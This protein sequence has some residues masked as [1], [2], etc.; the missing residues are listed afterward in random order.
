MLDGFQYTSKQLE[1][2]QNA[3]HRWNIA[4]GAVR[5]GKSHVALHHIIPQRVLAGRG[6]KGLNFLLGVSLGN[7][8][9]NVL[10]PMR[11]CFGSALVG[12]IRT[13]ENKARLFGEDVY[14]LGA[15]NK[16][17]LQR[18]Q[19]SEIKFC[20]CD[21]MANIDEDVFEMLKSRL[22]LPYSECHGA[23][24]PAG[25][26]H[27]LKQFIDRKDLDLYSQHYT[28]YDNP[29]LDQAVVAEICKEYQGTVFFDRL[30]EGRWV[31]AEGL[32]YQAWSGSEL[33]CDRE[34]SRGDIYCLSIDYGISNP[35][36]ALLWTVRGG[37]G[38][39]VDEY[40]WNG[41]QQG[42]LTDQQHLERLQEMLQGRW[43]EAV[44][45]DPSATSFIQ[46]L[47]QQTSWDVFPAKNAV[48]EGIANTSRAMAAGCI[49]IH[50]RCATVAK[51]LAEYSWDERAACDAVIKENDHA[52]D[53]MRYFV[54][55]IGLNALKC[56]E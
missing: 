41:R 26:R 11:E 13:N 40:S 38:Y 25:P 55:T 45:V 8:E 3:H 33:F 42:H 46:L 52:M 27:W 54:E 37:V 14:C 22:S 44:T 50:P 5:S 12:A 39:C 2:I 31:Q 23:C 15:N 18:L 19:G 16:R 51:E 35:F 48:L 28:L 36:V 47:R 17:A 9:R 7:I 34:F 4:E 56:F 1:Y 32:V 49:K 10:Q 43:V 6:R 20:Y 53:A 21:E 29:Y 24:N 30:V